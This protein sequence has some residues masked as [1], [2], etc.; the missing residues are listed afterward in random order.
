MWGW[1]LLK[2]QATSAVIDSLDLIELKKMKN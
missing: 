2:V 1:I